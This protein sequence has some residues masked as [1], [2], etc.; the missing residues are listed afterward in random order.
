M[1]SIH[2]V[3]FSSF[4]FEFIVF[5]CSIRERNNARTQ[6]KGSSQAEK[7]GF[8]SRNNQSTLQAS[9]LS[10]SRNK[11]NEELDEESRAG[12]ARLKNQD[13]E[14]DEGLDSISNCLD[15]LSGI[16]QAMNEEVVLLNL[17]VLVPVLFGILCFRFDLKT[18]SW[19][20]WAT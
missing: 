6:K 4:I 15:N 9:G 18:R 10:S 12:L 20:K 16:S 13:A 7:I 3:W 19:I 11:K 2:F 17:P 5:Y 1:N 14:I 8:V